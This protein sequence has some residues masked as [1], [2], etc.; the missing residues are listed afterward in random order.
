[1]KITH[2]EI[3][4]KLKD[5]SWIDF[6]ENNYGSVYWNQKTGEIIWYADD[7]KESNYGQP[8]DLIK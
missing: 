7:E 2:E 6:A 8:K 4:K 5:K 3:H 1:M